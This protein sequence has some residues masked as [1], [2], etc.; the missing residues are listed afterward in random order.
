MLSA[1]SP[2]IPSL[3]KYY[4]MWDGPAPTMQTIT[5][6][7]TYPTLCGGVAAIIGVITARW[8]GTRPVLS[9]SAALLFFSTIWACVSD[10]K[11][12]GLYSH[13]AARCFVG[14]GSGAFETV[15]PLIVQDLNYIHRRNT[16]IALVWGVGGAV[17]AVFGTASTYIVEVL[18]WRWFFGIINIVSGI[19]MIL[20]LFV[21]PET[22]WIRTVRD[23]SE[24]CLEDQT[25]SRLLT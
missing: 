1:M 12:R 8:I 9:F 11:D 6:L 15:V 16:L 24:F 22:S 14:L 25:L 10:G 21:V 20:I 13:I 2:I 18:G 5:N 7:A 4:A 23:L 3:I 19:G 17:S